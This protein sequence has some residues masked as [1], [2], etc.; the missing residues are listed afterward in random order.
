MAPFRLRVR[1]GRLPL[2]VKATVVALLCSLSVWLLLDYWQSRRLQEFAVATMSAELDSE[3]ASAR[4]IFDQEV[5]R[6]S[7]LVRLFATCGRVTAYLEASAQARPPRRGTSPESDLG[8]PPWVPKTSQWRG[9]I[10][11]EHFVLFS[12]RGE[13]LD[14]YALRGAELP[15]D[16]SRNRHYLLRRSTGQSYFAN[17]N[18]RPHLMATAEV[19][20]D[21]GRLRG[22]LM[23]VA[24]FDE[25]F[26]QSDTVRHFDLKGG[27]VALAVGDPA[28]G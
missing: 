18:G 11:P 23:V 22:Y 5:K 20:D 19:T 28:S 3:A 9:L 25:G 8:A 21:Q 1:L 17:L 14:S 24:P 12:S 26:L 16:L 2:Q 7:Q 10:D 13:I 4:L 6:Y 27:V 15:E